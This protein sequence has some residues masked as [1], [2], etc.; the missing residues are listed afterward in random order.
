MYVYMYTPIR[1]HTRL[2]LNTSLLHACTCTCLKVHIRTC[3]YVVILAVY[4][5]IVSVHCAEGLHFSLYHNCVGMPLYNL[6]PF[7]AVISAYLVEN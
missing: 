7:L 3:M 5:I 1:C 4:I 6:C 2:R